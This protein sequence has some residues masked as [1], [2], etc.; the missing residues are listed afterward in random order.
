VFTPLENNE[1]L[2]LVKRKHTMQQT[3][4]D[5]RHQ[6]AERWPAVQL[7]DAAADGEFVYAVKTTG[8]YCRPSCPSR[9]A[10]RQ[11]V[12]FFDTTFLAQAAGYRACKRC[13]P[14]GISQEHRRN[15]MIA[16]ACDTIKGNPKTTLATLAA[17]SGLSAYHFHRVFKEITG[18]TP[19]EYQKS[20]QTTRV[21]EALRVADSVTTAIYDAGFNSS[22]RFYEDAATTL[23][24]SPTQYRKGAM[25]EEI[26]YS[27]EPC[28]LGIII[29]A[30]TRRGVCA[31]EFGDSAHALVARLRERFP[32]AAF[33]PADTEFKKWIGKI[34]AYIEQPRGVLD[35]PLDVQGTVFQRRVWKALQEIPLGETASYAVVAKKIGKPS[36]VRA[37][38]QA[39]ASNQI[40]VAIPC[41]R[42]VRS[43]GALS[44][45]RW[46]TERKAE[47]LKREKK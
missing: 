8:V 35:L 13:K 14:D 21:A 30:A 31:I 11:N 1:S 32:H 27:A 22:S 29:V 46:G 19:K 4:L 36:A 17:A 9:A 42:V 23:G 15:D 20:L 28:A 33:Q 47:L 34:L 5:P 43:D 7:R 18:V 3:A 25:G 10:K 12:E 45:Y 39:C 40:A 6:A 44:G 37:V 2:P 41:H 24:M 26:R 16:A 38:A